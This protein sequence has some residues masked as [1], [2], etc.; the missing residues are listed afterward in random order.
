MTRGRRNASRHLLVLLTC[1]LEATL[2][3]CKGYFLVRRLPPF[4]ANISKRLVKSP[5]I[6]VRDS[7]MLHYLLGIS[8]AHDLLTSPARGNSFEGFMIEQITALEHLHRPGSG[9]YFFRTQTG[10]EIDL[11]VDRGQ[12]RIGFEFKAGSSV[13][14]RDWAHLQSGID[15]GVID[16]GNVIYHG[17]RRFPISD[18]ITAV[19]A[20]EAL[21]E[22]P[23]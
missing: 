12:I 21:S 3:Y 11:L 13:E 22:V 7:G 6:Y 23:D 17:T 8:S 9:V 1:K 5:K 19:P 15:D 2:L 4:H 16:R 14:P 10:R 20:D 18:R